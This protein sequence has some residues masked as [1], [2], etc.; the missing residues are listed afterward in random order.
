MAIRPGLSEPVL[1]GTAKGA[2]MA[3][4]SAYEQLILELIN[5][6]R[7]DPAAE[8]ARLGIGLND[9][10]SGG[11]ISS[12]AKPVLAANSDLIDAA[13][14]HSQWMLDTDIFS[15]TGAGGSS[16]T[17]RMLAV[18]YTLSGS[19]TTGE[20]IAWAGTTGSVN[21]EAYTQRLHDNLFKSAGHRLNILNA[22]FREIGIGELTGNFSGYNAAIVTEDFARSGSSYFITGVAITDADG[23]EFYDIGEAMAGIT[24]TVAG[25]GSDV[26]AAAG[27]YNVA[28]SSG[29]HTVTF[30]G[31][32]LAAPVSVTVAAGSANAKV[33]LAGQ[34]KILSSADTT[35]GAG[36]RDLT[37]LGVAALDGTGNGAANILKGNRSANA[38]DGQGG[39]DVIY[40]LAGNDVIDGG[41][42]NDIVA[43]LGK[44]S[45]FTIVENSDGSFTVTDGNTADGLNEGRDTIVG[46]EFLRFDGSG[47]TISLSG[48]SNPPPDPGPVDPPT[49]PVDPPI[50]PVDPNVPTTGADDLVGTSGDDDLDLLAGDDIYHAGAGDDAVRGSSGAD[51]LFGESGNDWLF[52]GVDGD[53]LFGG[54]DSD[55]LFGEDGDDYL[56]G[57]DGRDRTDGGAGNDKVLAGAGNDVVIGGDG[58]DVLFGEDGRDVIFG[59]D[60]NDRLFGGTEFD[61]L[62]G[63]AGADLLVGESGN[64][65]LFGGAGNDKL[66]GNDGNDRIDGG[67]G[68]RDIA[69]FSGASTRYDIQELAG[70]AFRVTDHTGQDGVD[71]LINVELALFTDGFLVL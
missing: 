29:T 43:F 19:W 1:E 57:G 9:N 13:I 69:V 47:D 7:L 60:G 54:S 39:D 27:G 28:V 45:D 52:G 44:Q 53:R 24:V 35:L 37:L 36:A 32:G 64:D 15:H 66:Y 48:S 8:A 22:S 63:G 16:P 5:R 51:E 26:T 25:Q 10:I 14:A 50:D 49:D 59:Q 67:A 62:V 65:R 42:G 6:A 2:R 61:K 31:G 46:A 70:G 71:I 40:G 11:S 4:N 38:L 3:T 58:N 56:N 41:A 55:K 18:G 21:L 30:S 33:D 34:N 12:A 17:Q 20:N 23:D 68:A